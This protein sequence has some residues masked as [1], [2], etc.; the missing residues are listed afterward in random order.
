[1][2]QLLVCILQKSWRSTFSSNLFLLGQPVF[3]SD[4]WFCKAVHLMQCAHFSLWEINTFNAHFCDVS[5]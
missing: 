1:M 4:R 5:V 3:S 2:K